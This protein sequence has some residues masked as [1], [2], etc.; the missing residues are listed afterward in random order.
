MIMIAN[1]KNAAIDDVTLSI[2]VKALRLALINVVSVG[3][4]RLLEDYLAG[5]AATAASNSFKAS[6]PSLPRA[7]SPSAQVLATPFIKSLNFALTSGC[8]VSKR[9]PAASSDG[10]V[11]FPFEFPRRGRY[12]V[13]VQ[14]KV[15]GE[16]VTGAFVV[17]V[18]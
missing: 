9:M 13:W 15:N 14:T 6:L 17:D 2:A 18:R 5:T 11:S 10:V 4:E 7:S 3:C 8:N 1:M 12:H 16:I